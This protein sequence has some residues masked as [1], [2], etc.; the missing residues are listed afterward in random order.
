MGMSDRVTGE[1]L[2]TRMDDIRAVMDAAGS[3]RAAIFG[4]AEGGAISRVFAATLPGADERA[5][6][7]R[8][9]APDEVG[10]RL[11]LGTAAEEQASAMRGSFMQLFFGSREEA[12]RVA[13]VVERAGSSVTTRS[14]AEIDYLRRAAGKSAVDWRR[15]R[16]CSARS[17]CGRC[18]PASA[19]R[20]S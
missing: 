18:Y 10:G 13:R 14:V 9:L 1:S 8:H 20:R 7:V 3:K 5:R 17:T 4:M 12:L 15:N 16:R 11:P 2:E 6:P 19:R